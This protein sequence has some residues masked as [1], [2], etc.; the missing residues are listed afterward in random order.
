MLM[1]ICEKAFKGF[2]VSWVIL[3]KNM[4]DTPKA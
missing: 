1:D 2:G 4:E 3:E